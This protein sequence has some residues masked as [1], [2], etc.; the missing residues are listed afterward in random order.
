MDL[1]IEL[2]LEL[3]RAMVRGA[4]RFVYWLVA[5]V[6]LGVPASAR[7]RIGAAAAARAETAWWIFTGVAICVS[8]VRLYHDPSSV[9][10]EVH[11]FVSLVVLPVAG[12]GVALAASASRPEPSPAEVR[13]AGDPRRVHVAARRRRRG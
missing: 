11:F 12:V 9:E 4:V 10:R 1:L 3:L 13:S 2:L 5:E 7:P 6:L 8:A